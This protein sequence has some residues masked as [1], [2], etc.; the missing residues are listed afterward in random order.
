[1]SKKILVIFFSV[2]VEFIETVLVKHFH[3]YHIVCCASVFASIMVTDSL[4]V[5]SN[6]P[7]QLISVHVRQV[8]CIFLVIATIRNVCI[9]NHLL[10]ATVSAK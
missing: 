1:M 2:Y 5:D 8:Q 10:M 9:F 4:V 6:G 3:K 7:R